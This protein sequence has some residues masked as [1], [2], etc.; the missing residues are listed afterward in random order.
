MA[1]VSKNF[2]DR[3]VENRLV[4]FNAQEVNYRKAED[5]VRCENCQH[6]FQRV[7]DKFHTCEIFR[8][9]ETDEKGVSPVYVCDF[10][11]IN[12][13]DFPLLKEDQDAD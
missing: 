4:K 13:V 2:Y 7:W 8:D 6:F 3:I 12:G 9:E 1:T 10:H 11:T 5:D